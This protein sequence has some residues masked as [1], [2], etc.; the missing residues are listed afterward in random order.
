MDQSERAAADAALRLAAEAAI[1]VASSKAAADEAVA[2]LAVHGEQNRVN[3]QLQLELR[4][5]MLKG[6]LNSLALVLR[7]WR[8]FSLIRV[9]H[10]WRQ[11]CV[12]AYGSEQA[13]AHR[14]VATCLRELED[15]HRLD[16]KD[17]A[18]TQQDLAE[19]VQRKENELQL[20]LQSFEKEKK[21]SLGEWNAATERLRSEHFESQ[22]KLKGEIDDL[23]RQVGEL[24]VAR[25][26]LEGDKIALEKENQYLSQANERLDRDKAVLEDEKQAIQA[27]KVNR[28]RLCQEH[29][30]TIQ[31]LEGQ[32]EDDAAKNKA[33]FEAMIDGTRKLNEQI[34]RLQNAE[35]SAQSKAASEFDQALKAGQ[36]QVRSAHRWFESQEIMLR[37]EMAAQTEELERCKRSLNEAQDRAAKCQSDLSSWEVADREKVTAQVDAVHAKY[38]AEHQSQLEVVAA[39]RLE[40]T[41]LQTAAKE[42]ADRLRQQY[43]EKMSALREAAQSSRDDIHKQEHSMSALQTQN[44]ALTAELAAAKQKFE[45]TEEFHKRELQLVRDDT[46]RERRFR[47]SVRVDDERDTKSSPLNTSQQHVL[48]EYK[49]RL[50]EV[51][52]QVEEASAAQQVLVL[53]TEYSR[54]CRCPWRAG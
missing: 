19:A 16:V 32:L 12:I 21:A 14:D 9:V 33:R 23:D 37:A 49:E 28:E 45:T 24:R 41:E 31:R 51:Q 2:N 35:R 11:W 40:N 26:A 20:A 27:D 6:G 36:E 46:A 7:R 44:S 30:L 53:E 4:T 25:V 48:H 1:D 47:S 3:M 29:C 13:N 42:H 50:A 39:L 54:M 34:E 52:A 10:L 18:R 17:M 22:L 43:E 15:A 8:C 38:R 5:A